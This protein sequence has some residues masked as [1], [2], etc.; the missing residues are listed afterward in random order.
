MSGGVDSSVAASLLLEQGHDVT[1]AYMINYDTD[2]RIYADDADHADCSNDK[3]FGECWRNDY[4]DALRVAA[5]LDI[6][7]IKLDFKKE[8]HN[9]VLDYMFAEYEKGRT[10][11]P[12]VLCNKFIKFGVWLEKA[13]EL[14]FSKLATGH[15]ARLKRE[16]TRNNKQETNKF[17]YHLMEAKDKEKDQTY[18]L[19]QLAQEQLKYVLFPLGNYTK[20][21]VRE[22][23]K[24]MNLPTAEKEESMGICF[25]GEVPMKE[26]LSKKIKQ[27]KGNVLT[28]SGETIGE[29]DGLPF[30][31]IGQRHFGI[32]SDGKGP[33]YIVGKNI[34]KNELVVG[35]ENDP[36]FYKKEAKIIDINWISGQKRNFPLKCEVRLRHRQKKQKAVLGVKNDKL[37][38]EFDKPQK[39]VTPGQFAVFYKKGECLG[40][41]VIE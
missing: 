11:N 17:I 40:G 38:V 6:P 20:K 10:P 5:K 9:F 26:F 30:Y 7:L 1:G 3:K 16:E 23:A 25:V 31:T 39:A 27:K 33:L 4:R 32:Q 14:G 18:F 22:L 13:K 19:H 28:S 15:Y 41:G 34:K 21:E 12:D 24:K 36:L 29:H 35:D 37:F 2:T 8:Y